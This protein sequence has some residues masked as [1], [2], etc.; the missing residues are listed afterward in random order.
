[1]MK[2]SKPFALM[3]ASTL[4]L[5]TVLGGCSG[6]R[7]ITEAE[8]ASPNAS[9]DA[10]KTD[11]KQAPLKV[12]YIVPDT[13]PPDLEAVE[14][15]VS[16]KMQ[17]DGLNLELDVTFIP[18]DVLDEKLNIMFTSG[19]EV[20]LLHIMENRTSSSLYAARGVLTPLDELIEQYGPALKKAFPDDIWKS[21]KVNGN[22]YTVPS[23]WKAGTRTGGET[24]VFTIR[25][26]LLDKYN[27]P[28]PKSNRE[29]LDA[30]EALKQQWGE[31]EAYLWPSSVSSNP[32]FLHRDY[33]SW[34]FYVDYST[35]LM[36]VD[37]QGNVKAWVETEE[38]KQDSA[39]F[40]EAYAKG[41]LHPDFLSAPFEQRQKLTDSGIWLSGGGGDANKLKQ[42]YPDYNSENIRLQ[43]DKPVLWTIPVLN[44]NA[45]PATTKHPEAGIQFLNW[46]YSSKE[47]HDLLMFGIEGT[48][49]KVI[50][51]NRIETVKDA[52]GKEVYAFPYWQIGYKDWSRF[53]P[54]AT[55]LDIKNQ[56]E[57]AENLIPSIT[58]GFR[59]DTAPVDTEYKNVL[60]EMKASIYPIK[61]GMQD[62]DSHF[63]KALQKLKAAGLDKI[64]A[65]YDKQFKAWRQTEAR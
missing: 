3:G 15:A 34:P 56:K 17:K 41:L 39:F 49:Y 19:E 37:Q 21:T 20:E 57:H 7:S 43:P 16:E 22:I 14:K 61:F 38:F 46:L 64:V 47:N 2:V 48:H 26:D 40:R 10:P 1:M 53:K 50:D 9:N 44:A 59:F 18:R 36:Y 60:A 25:R 8:S 13:A 5:V 27:I 51:D 54:E 42:V 45:V 58:L 32:V 29:L 11:N 28:V 65:E 33:D 23:Y 24:G 63:P 6:S 35:E 31:K 12:R 30:A 4:L 52:G 62:Y 55:D